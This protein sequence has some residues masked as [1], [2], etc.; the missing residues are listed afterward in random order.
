MAG[1]PAYKRYCA[2]SHA[3]VKLEPCEESFCIGDIV[4]RRLGK[5]KIRMPIDKAGNFIQY[6]ADVFDVNIPILLGLDM[7]KRLRWYVN[8]I[9]NGF[10]SND[11][12][13]RT[14]PLQ[15]RQAHLYPQWPNFIVLFTRQDLVKL[16]RRFRPPPP[17]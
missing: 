15:P 8:E 11:D 17:T 13:S 6:T 16:H 14:I 10:C 1:L 12:K 5:A 2:H 4:Q 7:M 3:D 9:M